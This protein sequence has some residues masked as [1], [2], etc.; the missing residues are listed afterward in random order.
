MP[1]GAFDRGAVDVDQVAVGAAEGDAQSALLELVG[2]G[3]GVLD[4]LRLQ[5]LELLGLRELE[6][7]RQR[8]KD[9]DVRSA[10]FAGEDGL[11]DLLGDGRRRWSAAPRRADRRGSC[12]WWT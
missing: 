9:M 1:S 2:H 3:L 10:L 12:A 4:G 11:V 5:L 8:G 7:Q 6:G